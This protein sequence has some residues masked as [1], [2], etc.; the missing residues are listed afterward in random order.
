MKNMPRA[1]SFGVVKDEGLFD[2]YASRPPVGEWKGKLIVKAWG[3]SVNVICFFEDIDSGEKYW[4]SAFRTQG[5]YTPQDKK[6]DFSEAGIDG[7]VY[8]LETGLNS[9]GRPAWLRAEELN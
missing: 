4:L 2:E 9:K 6:I 5:G 8:L 7:R 3:K 1:L